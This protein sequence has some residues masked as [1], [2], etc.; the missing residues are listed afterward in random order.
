MPKWRKLAKS[1]H[2]E[3]EAWPE[4]NHGRG[5]YFQLRHSKLIRSHLTHVAG[6]AHKSKYYQYFAKLIPSLI[7]MLHLWLVFNY[8]KQKF[9][10]AISII[11]LTL[12]WVSLRPIHLWFCF[13]TKDTCPCYLSD[14]VQIRHII[15]LKN[16]RRQQDIN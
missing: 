16:Q 2:I 7:R 3:L 13:A 8:Q 15:L 6:L 1:G 11:I 5:R 14:E 9:L 10:K 4:G 12:F